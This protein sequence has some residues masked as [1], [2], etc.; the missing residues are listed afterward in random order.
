ML[1]VPGS[2]RPRELY[3]HAEQH[4]EDSALNAE[5]VPEHV[6]LERAVVDALPAGALSLHDVYLVHGSEPN[7]SARRRAGFVIRYMPATSHYDRDKAR[8]GSNLVDTKLADR[9]LF[10]VRGVDWTGKTAPEIL[11][12]D[13]RQ[14]RIER[15]GYQHTLMI[16]V[17]SR[18][19]KWDRGV[20]DRAA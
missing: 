15:R 10:L 16:H 6:D 2:Q 14:Q 19:I 20:L 1:Y 5:L 17:E 7:R 4:S 12:D 3:P 18:F 11:C 9:P 8:A 13:P